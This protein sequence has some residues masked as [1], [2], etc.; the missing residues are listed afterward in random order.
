MKRQSRRRWLEGIAAAGV[1]PLSACDGPRVPFDAEPVRF[2]HGVASGDPTPDSVILWTRV[3]TGAADDVELALE[4]G[5][6]PNLTRLTRRASA[7]ALADR[8]H[9]A[10]TE[11]RELE[12][13]TSY[14]YRFRAGRALS[15]IGRFRT[16]ERAELARLRLAVVSCS[17]FAHGYFHAY[18]EIAARP[19]L[20]AVVHLG[21]YIYE[22]G[23]GTF[24]SERELDPDHECVSLD[25][26]RRRYRHYR[27][28]PDLLELHRQ[29]TV[30]AVWDD[31]EVANDAWVGGS[32][33]HD[34]EREGDWLARRAAAMRAYHEWMPVREARDGRLQ[35]AVS[36]GTL[37]DLVLI[38]TRHWG[39]SEPVANP[40][41]A[42]LG[43]AD[44]SIL[45]ADQEAWL[46]EQL[47]ASRAAWKL[48]GNQ[49]MMTQLSI[50]YNADAWDGYPA[51]RRRLLSFIGERE[52]AGVVV[53]TGDIHMSWAS[54]LAL[55]PE[56]QESYDPETSEGAVAVE[57]TTPAV[58]SPGLTEEAAEL[59]E[60]VVLEAPHVRYAELSSRGY[61]LIDVDAD[62]LLAEYYHFERVDRRTATSRLA[63]VWRVA[64]NRA[65]LAPEEEASTPP[66]GAPVLASG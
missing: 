6:D 38:D 41:E 5:E 33:N 14:Y 19:D 59:A 58:T 16:T 3:T 57:F 15:P 29:H 35:R 4:I 17:S 25:D 44:R 65:R 51:S 13:A 37:A 56:D 47:G 60:P 54:E 12:A 20:D 49:V 63:S 61:L 42:A 34:P 21:D 8:D 50:L 7:V 32:P 45:G 2:D 66:E 55:D 1:A 10:K 43:D 22:S 11:L 26:Y 27:A 18:R 46:T 24:G 31:H 53:L 52:I 9:T 64:P 28:D 36:F 23:S 40:D 48:I 62:R 39:R 30:I